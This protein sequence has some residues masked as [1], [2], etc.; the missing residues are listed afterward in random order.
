[1][2]PVRT[3]ARTTGRHQRL[4][5]AGSAVPVNCGFP[6]VAATPLPAE[7]ACRTPGDPPV[8]I[9]RATGGDDELSRGICI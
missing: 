1:M 3:G 8:R 9:I 5:H 6:M 7:R 4:T 2:T